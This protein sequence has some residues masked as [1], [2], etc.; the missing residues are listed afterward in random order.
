M[1]CLTPLRLSTSDYISNLFS[2]YQVDL[3]K[4]MAKTGL[5]S[6]IQGPLSAVCAQAASLNNDS[7]NSSVMQASLNA[8]CLAT[9]SSLG[10][11]DQTFVQH[12]PSV[13]SNQ[14]FFGKVPVASH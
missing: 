6:H 9:P 10:M 13:L 7:N 14:S 2:I 5:S 3:A 1:G 12:Q 8:N 4:F 11:S